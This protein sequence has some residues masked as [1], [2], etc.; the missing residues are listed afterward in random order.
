MAL[1]PFYYSPLL[2]LL[3]FTRFRMKNI[4]LFGFSVVLCCVLC[5]FCLLFLFLRWLSARS[6][7]SLYFVC[8]TGMDGFVVFGVAFNVSHW[9]VNIQSLLCSR[10]NKSFSACAYVVY[11]CFVW[12]FLIMQFLVEIWVSSNKFPKLFH[13]T[14][15][16]GFFFFL[17]WIRFLAHF[18]QFQVT[19]NCIWELQKWIE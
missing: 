7:S 15:F 6:F 2:L 19:I 16:S 3:L 17:K 12:F 18:W 1:I 13:R 11:L 9:N 8:S 4:P 10:W 5:A 14:V